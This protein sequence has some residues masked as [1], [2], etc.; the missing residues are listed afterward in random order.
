MAESTQTRSAVVGN[1]VTHPDAWVGLAEASALIGLSNQTVWRMGLDGVIR[2]WILG[3]KKA[4]YYK[5]DLL[6]YLNRNGNPE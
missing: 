4:K 2:R 6:N 1:P 3:T 5:P